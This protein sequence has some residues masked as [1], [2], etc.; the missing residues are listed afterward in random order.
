MRG[1]FCQECI[2]GLEI[3]GA[4]LEDCHFTVEVTGDKRSIPNREIYLSCG[5]LHRGWLNAGTVRPRF[6]FSSRTNR[7]RVLLPASSTWRDPTFSAMD[8]GGGGRQAR[9]AWKNIVEMPLKGRALTRVLRWWRI[10]FIL[11]GRLACCS[12]NTWFRCFWKFDRGVIWSVFFDN[13]EKRMSCIKASFK[14]NI[15]CT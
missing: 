5:R 13:K 9:F 11:C 1:S 7:F 10:S 14:K 3:P 4:S 12:G 8:G 2:T 15:Y 6:F